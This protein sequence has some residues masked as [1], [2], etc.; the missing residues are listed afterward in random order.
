VAEVEDMAILATKLSRLFSDKTGTTYKNSSVSSDYH[1]YD[2]SDLC[3][4]NQFEER[5]KLMLEYWR[6]LRI[7]II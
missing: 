5:Y 2:D 3:L 6:K 7:V 4:W 1:P